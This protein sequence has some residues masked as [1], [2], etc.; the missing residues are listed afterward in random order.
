MPWFGFYLVSSSLV[1]GW[2]PELPVFAV[3]FGFWRVVFVVW[4]CLVFAFGVGLILRGVVLVSFELVF[5][6]FLLVCWYLCDSQ[7][8]SSG[9]CGIE[10][11]RCLLLD[12]CLVVV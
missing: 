2:F 11:L 1:L 12:W 9:C 8:D 6:G 5:G 7:Y 3:R 4:W 10:L